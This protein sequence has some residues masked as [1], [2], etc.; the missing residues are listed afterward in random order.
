MPNTIPNTRTEQPGGRDKRRRKEA[1]GKGSE[2]HNGERE[3]SRHP[4]AEPWNA[5]ANWARE[6]EEQK[7]TKPEPHGRQATPKPT[8]P[9]AG[10]RNEPNTKRRGASGAS[11]RSTQGE[12]KPKKTHTESVTKAALRWPKEHTNQRELP[13]ERWGAQKC[14]QRDRLRDPSKK[15]KHTHTRI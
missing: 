5:A 11:E 7:A 14:A 10:N 15:G 13:K 9:G 2:Q 3:G 4:R 8:A 12:K 1:R 6:K